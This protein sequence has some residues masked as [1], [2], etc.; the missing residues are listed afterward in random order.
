MKTIKTF[1]T[2]FFIAAT[3][4]LGF[5]T[6]IL[7]FQVLSWIFC[8]L[9]FLLNFF[10]ALYVTFKDQSKQKETGFSYT[11]GEKIAA[12]LLFLPLAAINLWIINGHQIFWV[13]ASV[14]V[15]QLFLVIATPNK[16]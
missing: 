2:A 14:V 15:M 13:Y 16:K 4:F 3:F 9:L 6:D 8:G 1:F 10:G 7:F 11:L 12:Q 5:R